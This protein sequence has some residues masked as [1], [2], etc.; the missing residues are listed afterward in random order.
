MRLATVLP[1]IG[2]VAVAAGAGGTALGW[3]AGSA[4]TLMRLVGDEDATV[5]RTVAVRHALGMDRAHGLYGQDL[6]VLHSRFPDV[7]D[8]FFVDVGSADGVHL[9][10]TKA[11]EARGWRGVCIDPFPR[12]METRTCRTVARP[13]DAEAGRVLRFFE[14]GTFGGGLLEYAGWWVSEQAKARSV[15]VTTTTLADVLERAGAPPFI[16]Y[17]NL[18]IEGAEYEALRTFPFDRYRIGALTVEHNNVESRRAAIREL[19][20]RHGYRLEWAIRDQ[21]WYVPA[22]PEDA[23]S[24]DAPD[25]GVRTN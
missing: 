3:R 12:N 18:D 23:A 6:W 8:G 17:M 22:E 2:I 19:L 21:D 4:D 14:P 16:H 10:N 11:L 15:E 24:S 7:R 1:M 5:R 25:T 13:V 9:S 20:E